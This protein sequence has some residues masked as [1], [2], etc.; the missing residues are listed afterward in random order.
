MQF[1]LGRKRAVWQKL[2]VA[3][4][5]CMVCV[6]VCVMCLCKLR[7]RLR[8][9]GID[10]ATTHNVEMKSDSYCSALLCVSHDHNRMSTVPGTVRLPFDC[11]VSCV[12]AAGLGL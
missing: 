12:L 3:H 10:D 5:H 8:Y 1:E 4:A 2:N 9:W 11:S 6:G 7:V